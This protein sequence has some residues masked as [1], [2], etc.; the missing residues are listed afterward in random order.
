MWSALVVLMVLG[1]LLYGASLWGVTEGFENKEGET[2]LL[3]DPDEYYDEFYASF[4]DSLWHTPDVIS[5]ERASLREIA[6]DGRDK[7]EI[8][9]LD[10]GCGTAPHACWFGETGLK[11]T[12]MDSSEGMLDK[13]RKNCPSANFVKGDM[14]QPS[15]FAPKS[16]THVLLMNQTVYQFPNPKVLAD[17]ASYWLQPEGLCVVHMVH[18]NKFD[19]VLQLASP[20]AAFSMQKYSADRVVNSEIYYDQFKYQSKFLKKDDADEAK[21]QETITFYDPDQNKG[22]K[23]REQTQS[24]TMPSME[25]LIDIFK[26]SGFRLKEVVDLV[27]CGKEYQYLVYFEK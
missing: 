9:V 14:R 7:N 18:P 10:M 3:N 11:Y 12:G 1:I 17:N 24:L 19:P 5:Y 21:W 16:F 26:G 6:L 2:I 20:F 4:Y 23:F 13:A 22:V 8:S 25:R 27:S 15:S